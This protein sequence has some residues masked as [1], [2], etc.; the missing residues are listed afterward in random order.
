MLI[1]YDKKNGVNF[2]PF[3]KQ[4][5]EMSDAF[6]DYFSNKDK[7]FANIGENVM[8]K[9]DFDVFMDGIGKINDKEIEFL[10]NVRKTNGEIL[11]GQDFIEAYTDYASEGFD[12]TNLK[13]KAAS[14]ATGALNT[15]IQMGISMLASMAISMVVNAI[16]DYIHRVELAK[17]ASERAKEKIDETNKTFEDQKKTLE[18]SGKRYA[19]LAQHVN[20]F[21]NTN[22]DLNEDEYK[23]F[24]KLSDELAEKFP[25][26]NQGV[27]ENGHA[28]L[29]LNGN[30]SDIN[31]TLTEYIKLAK[32]AAQTK[33]YDSFTGSN[34][35]DDYFEGAKITAD[36]YK[37]DIA[38]SKKNY[39]A[40]VEMQNILSDVQNTKISKDTFTRNAQMT[41]IENRL[42]EAFS[43]TNISGD[44]RFAID[45]YIRR[46][47][48]ELDEDR[49]ASSIEEFNT[50]LGQR[51]YDYSSA[52]RNAEANLDAQNK[53]ISANGQAV[54]ERSAM[55]VDEKDQSVKNAMMQAFN[56]I[57]WSQLDI[58]TGKDA[59][60][61]IQE[62]FSKEIGKLSASEK[63]DFVKLFAPPEDI[64]LSEYLSLY[65]RIKNI[66]EK[67]GVKIPIGFELQDAKEIQN[68]FK[69]Q[70][71]KL[72]A[73]DRLNVLDYF[74]SN[75]INSKDEIDAWNKRT[76]GA[77]SYAE[78]V[79]MYEKKVQEESEKTAEIDLSSMSKEEQAYEKQKQ[80][81]Q[82]L[83][84]KYEEAKSK[85]K[86]Q[87]SD[88]NY[89][90]NVDINN[91]PTIPMDDGSYATSLT[92][93]REGWYGDEENGSY[94][95]IHYTPILPNGE[96][97]SDE[98]LDKYV[99]ELL[100]KK[101]PLEADKP[102]NGGKGIVYK[103][104]TKVDGKKIDDS[105]LEEAF[106][107]ADD[108]DVQMHEKQNSIYETEGNIV[109]QIEKE[110]AKMLELQK[111]ANDSK[112]KSAWK[113]LDNI[114]TSDDNKD[115]DRFK[116][117]KKSLIDLADAGKLTDKEFKK[118][119]DAVA[120]AKSLGLSISEVVKEVNNLT[121]SAKQ[122]GSLKSAI[123]SI[124]DA[125]SS[126]KENK[127]V[128]ADTLASM[129]ATFGKL[130]KAWTK[131]KQVAG[132]TKTSL[133]DLKKAQN[134]LATA[135]VNSNNFLSG[136][137][138]KTGEC[139]EANKQYYISQLQELGIKNAEEVVNKSIIQAQEE[140]VNQKI[141]LAF[142]SDD[143]VGTIFSEVDG[144]IT[145][146][147]EIDLS[148][149]KYKDYVFYKAL[150]NK[151]ALSTS[152]SVS[153]LIALARQ[154]GITGEAIESLSTLLSLQQ[155]LESLSPNAPDMQRK[156]LEKK[157]QTEQNNLN[158]KSKEKVKVETSLP[159]VEVNP[160]K[161][162]AGS[163][164]SGSSSSS[165]S[166]TKQEFDWI[167]RRI[168]SL[169]NKISLYNAQ[170][171]N[172]FTV[173]N[174]NKNLN[175]QIK[176]TTKLLN[177]YRSAASKY[178]AKANS[179]KLSSSL[180][181][182][183]RNGQ[184][185]GSYKSL[186]KEY[187][188]T[189]AN[190][191]QKYQDYY[192]KS[193]SAKQDVAET[194]TN[195]RNLQI[196]K[197]Q[198]YVDHY[199]SLMNK[200]KELASNSALSYSKRNSYINDEI[201]N[202][203][204][205]Y[206]YQIKIANANKNTAEATRLQAELNREIVG[207]K[208]EQF[209]NV[210]TKYDRDIQRNTWDMDA[211]DRAISEIEGRG[212]NVNRAYYDREKI[213]NNE[214]LSISREELSRLQSQIKNIPK[215]TDEWYDA[216]DDINDC[217]NRISDSV[218]TSYEL[219][220]K[221][222]EL[223][224]K[225]FENTREQISRVNAEQEFLRG[226]FAHEKSFD[227]DTGAITEE[228]FARLGSFTT[229]YYLSKGNAE[230]DEDY[231]NSLLRM[232]NNGTWTA[233][234]N[235]LDDLEKEIDS[236]YTTWQNDIK[237]TY[238][239]ENDI[240]NMM[241]ENYQAQLDALKKLIDKRKEALSIEKEL[242]DYQRQIREKTTAITDT[243][244]QI[245]AYRGDTSSE[246]MARMQRLQKQLADQQDDLRETEYDRYISDQQNMLDKLY[247]EFEELIS[248]K[249]DE[250]MELVK[251]GLKIGNENATTT[252]K[253]LEEVAKDNG[254]NEQYSNTSGSAGVSATIEKLKQETESKSGTNANTKAPNNVASANSHSIS[255]SWSPIVH[256][257]GG[258]TY[259]LNY[260]S[261]A[262]DF[263][264]WF[265]KKNV[266]TTKTKFSKLTDFNKAVYTDAGKLGTKKKILSTGN[267]KLLASYLG[268]NYDNS[269]R[270]GS[271]YKKVKS[272]GIKGFSHGGIVDIDDIT[273]QVRANG[274]TGIASVKNGEGILTP[275]E[276]KAFLKLADNLD[277]MNLA[278]DLMKNY[279]SIPNVLDNLSNYG[280]NNSVNEV[281]YGGVNFNFDVHGNNPSEMI[282]AIQNN[283]QLQKAIEKVSV[284]KL[285]NNNRLGVRSIK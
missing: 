29:N 175:K 83:I 65:E 129:E 237:E 173:K 282:R 110:K 179:V 121:D 153:N 47:E 23:E 191:I 138:D 88:S 250:F 249:L 60:R 216:Q 48:T 227:A 198:N 156:I 157:I 112:F 228:G 224:N 211:L 58:E 113:A 96:I 152:E 220:N 226:L 93:F 7:P 92:A 25:T 38:E 28:I 256:T 205:S 109:S 165:K 187:G 266:Q 1:K 196:E 55:Y 142:E 24:L 215:Y 105:N 189:T 244:R 132:S 201:K 283:P 125:Y 278:T 14:I 200:F 81:V 77:K 247:S 170:K 261:D 262:Q 272:L 126:K 223:Y 243:Q 104:D 123:G 164:S 150:A 102:E 177:T 276:T 271:L 285:T 183:V 18:E 80:K 72:S 69:Q 86:E 3:L 161:S 202:L 41:D 98:A 79:E 225:L 50:L 178:E 49:L 260:K 257:E 259:N 174:K 99:G 199:D 107:K 144:L 26:F 32:D 63:E 279:S 2:V 45:T 192:D 35:E 73:K 74:E 94:R 68:Q 148:I 145:E 57:D 19:E 190:R 91:R 207:L 100:G 252:D 147:G 84:D 229:S 181:K 70:L 46:F 61:Y 284:G 274:D 234:F 9:E 188:E 185:T 275:V 103:V 162:G 267:Q 115:D 5:T 143:F 268:L 264:K 246:G 33:L 218:K 114:D 230:N 182:K 277:A 67:H 42:S 265:L 21:N 214:N 168:T 263:I 122:L 128:G 82:E 124:Q 15:A 140:L 160:T 54:L 139:T 17:E 66:F 75:S 172:L 71:S 242:H 281:N 194:E 253:Y 151:N 176:E 43:K 31:E 90:G 137:I 180:K 154:C 56:V 27:D 51:A 270:S 209:D 53:Q 101:N 108:W 245:A 280:N 8:S 95:V 16:D 206:E 186:I 4:E 241:K 251:E 133:K 169:T 85:R 208:K 155:E 219:T 135:Y 13:A 255:G 146:N 258:K 240:F 40:I 232:K 36:E 235:S 213:I 120:W 195:I 217:L 64:D 22:L 239:V 52:L 118:N 184:I 203:K 97:L 44:D 197:L 136:L 248:K 62:Q 141:E 59:A 212:Q 12:I 149:Q 163:G 106:K 37:E 130:G 116:D 167:E 166:N 11:N 78:A 39:E 131:Y 158:K 89:I 236:V 34:G 127:V 254:Y 117:I 231:L 76:E 238:S 273:K 20:Q 221:I 204:K 222:H 6:K 193:R 159:D 269:T 233:Q 171:E 10:A 111:V 134:E 119:K 87:Y 30:I 210:K